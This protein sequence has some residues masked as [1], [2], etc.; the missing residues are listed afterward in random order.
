[1]NLFFEE[2]GDFKVGAILSQQG[3]AYQVET[4]SGKRTKVRARDVLLQFDTPSAA[5]MMASANRL[6][7]DI[8]IAFLW[9]VAGEDEF[10]VVD[11]GQEYFG[12]AP[13][14]DEAAG[15]LLKIAA[16]PIYFH[17]KG[18]GRYKAAPAATLQAALA[19]IEKKKQQ[20]LQ[21]QAMLEQLTAGELPDAI[22]SGV[23]Q[24][25][26]KP[27][28]NSIEYKALDAACSA[29]Q[30]SPARLL[31]KLG[32]IASAKQLHLSRFL[33]EH[34]PRGTEFSSISLP[35]IPDLPL[36]D[37]AAFSIDDV[38]TTEIDDAFS[39]TRLADGSL[40]IGIHIAAPGLGITQGDTIDGMARDR[41]STVYMP[42]DKITML[43]DALVEQFTLAAGDARAALSL[44]ATLESQS[45]S[46]TATE[47]LI[48]RVPIAANLRHNDLDAEVTEQSLADGSGDY[49]YKDEITTLWQWAQQLEAAR[50]VKREAFGLRPE[51]VNRVD[52]NFYVDDDVVTITRR[53]RGAPLDKIV[54]ELMIFANS[55]WGKLMH[56]HGVPGIYRAQGGGQGWN[57]RMQV[58][59]QTHAAPHQG[60]GVDQYAW[61]TSPLRRYT[62]LVNQWQIMACIRGGVTAPLVAPF[63]HKDADLFAIVSAFDSAYSAYA[64]FQSTMER[65]WCLRWLAQQ[66]LKQ[67]EAVLLKDDVLRLVDIP[68]VITMP[69]VRHARGTQ[70][71]LELIQWDEV[72]LTVQA[73]VLEVATVSAD[74][75]DEIALEEA[76]ALQ[77]EEQAA[78]QVID[79]DNG[80]VMDASAAS[81]EEPVPVLSDQ[82]ATTAQTALPESGRAS[83][84]H[85]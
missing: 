5:E 2:S 19:G 22:K 68:L 6:S 61:S 13:K 52:F 31:L 47:T 20:A 54:A 82:A 62:D 56:E 63:K 80:P 34:F 17:K 27:D 66:E 78:E 23:R 40:R 49:P 53:K 12:H 21:Q 4:P 73:R 8:D 36:A 33:T 29:L 28:K 79:S 10:G 24:L 35:S 51:Q 32:A 50:M 81:G 42:G 16:S 70:V 59:M 11:L 3:E 69:G 83:D 41:M 64:D 76:D 45:W 44:Y 38:T 1:M 43:P 75:A 39:V 46:V 55:T 18:K 37:V 84:D 65:F 57:A 71:K 77:E 15:L 9:E 30:T 25:L 74:L 58:R 85:P 48:E 26:T 14:P 67:A 7:E 72:D 60:L